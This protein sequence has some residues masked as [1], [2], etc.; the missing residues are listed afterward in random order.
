MMF[1]FF[2]RLCGLSIGGALLSCAGAKP[3]SVKALRQTVGAP[4]VKQVRDS[5]FLDETEVANLHWLEYL[6]FIRQD[7]TPTFYQSQ[8][9]DSTAQPRLRAGKPASGAKADTSAA[10]YLRHPAYRYYPVVGITVAQAAN[11][12][13]WR[14]AKVRQSIAN[15]SSPGGSVY[16]AKHRKALARYDLTA[17]YR[18]PTPAEWELAASAA[19]PQPEIPETTALAEVMSHQANALGIRNLQGNVAELTALPSVIKGGSWLQP[20]V[21]VRADLANPG[22]KPWLGFR[23]ACE[24][25]LSPKAP[26]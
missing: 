1:R 20:A 13:R 3:A 6:H 7:S 19:A 22:P 14:T 15:L 2:L 5:L 17:T 25:Q 23:C 10:S 4:G 24:V 16:Y 11:Y 26:K 8:L 9:P 18:L 21:P 12:C